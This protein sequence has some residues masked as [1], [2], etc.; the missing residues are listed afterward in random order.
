MKS[1]KLY[2]KEFPSCP[3]SK[4][5]NKKNWLSVF[6]SAA[7]LFYIISNLQNAPCW[8]KWSCLSCHPVVLPVPQ[9]AKVLETAMGRPMSPALHLSME[10]SKNLTRLAFWKKPRVNKK[11]VAIRNCS[12]GMIPL[13]IEKHTFWWIPLANALLNLP[14]TS[15]PSVCP[16][17]KSDLEG[18]FIFHYW[19][20]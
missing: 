16:S 17:W 10:A 7:P 14:V 15:L 19:M 8:S 13:Q 4:V 18:L 3:R 11:H 20:N 6:S 2:P 9:G 5:E 1:S 12:V